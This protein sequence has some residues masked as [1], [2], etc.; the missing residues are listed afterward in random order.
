MLVVSRRRYHRR[1]FYLFEVAVAVEYLE[2]G[3]NLGF[4][5]IGR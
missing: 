4:P 2:G 1:I 5:L 3:T